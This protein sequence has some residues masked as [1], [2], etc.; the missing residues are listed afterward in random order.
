VSDSWWYNP[1]KAGEMLLLTLVL[2]ENGVC[3]S[4][5]CNSNFHYEDIQVDCET[6]SLITYYQHTT[7]I[8]LLE[9][10]FLVNA[11]THSDTVAI[12]A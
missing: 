3:Q 2:V 6:V 5:D 7:F 10:V 11:I 1:F 9:A 4:M 8:H 12:S